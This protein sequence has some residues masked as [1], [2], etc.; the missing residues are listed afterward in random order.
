MIYYEVVHHII[1]LASNFHCSFISS[2]CGACMS[3]LVFWP[4]P[5]IA[6]ASGVLV[7]ACWSWSGVQTWT[8]HGSWS[9]AQLRWSAAGPVMRGILLFWIVSFFVFFVWCCEW[10]CYMILGY[11]TPEPLDRTLIQ[12]IMKLFRHWTWFSQGLLLPVIL[13]FLSVLSKSLTLW[14]ESVMPCQECC[15]ASTA[16]H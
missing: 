5:V 9:W 1:V 12:P 10:I 3:L 6:W 2:N 8:I 13:V 7:L 14:V 11:F 16:C 15:I 4:P